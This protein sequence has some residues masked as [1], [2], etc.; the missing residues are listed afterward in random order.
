MDKEFSYSHRKLLKDE[1]IW[2]NRDEKRTQSQKE[3]ERKKYLKGSEF[4]RNKNSK[5]KKCYCPTADKFMCNS[6]FE[7]CICTKDQKVLEIS[8][9]QD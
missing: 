1:N 8:E 3:Q 2:V 7:T 4:R 5:T 9:K 6:S